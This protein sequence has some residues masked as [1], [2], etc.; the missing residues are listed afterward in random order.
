LRYRY[1]KVPVLNQTLVV[2]VWV[3]NQISVFKMSVL[4]P[5][6]VANK[7]SVRRDV[8]IQM[9]LPRGHIC[10]PLLTLAI[11]SRASGK[12]LSHTEISYSRLE[13]S[14]QSRSDE[15]LR[16]LADNAEAYVELHHTVSL[17]RKSRSA[18]SL[19]E[20]AADTQKL[21]CL[22]RCNENIVD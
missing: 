4:N 21:T 14:A 5:L 16:H 2:N 6:P 3:L 1:G 20:H 18:P 7:V 11:P 15:L 10:T 9:I 12:H 19:L 17:K 8:L 13:P 22:P